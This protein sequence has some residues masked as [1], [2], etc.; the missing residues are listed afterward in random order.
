DQLVAIR[1]QKGA[2]PEERAITLCNAG[3][4]ALRGDVALAILDCIADN[5]AQKEFYLVDAV[6]I[7]HKRGLRTVAI[8]T[9]ADEVLGI[10]NKLKLAQ[11]EALMQQRLRQA[12][13][14]NGV[15]MIAPDTVHL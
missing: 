8:E 15:S 1:E 2:G 10:D 14:E 9:G 6:A 4:M 7:A 12:A 11:G 5:N 3:L 13:L